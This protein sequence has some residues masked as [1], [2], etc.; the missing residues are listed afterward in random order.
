MEEDADCEI[1]DLKEKYEQRLG[2]ERCAHPARGPR[3]DSSALWGR[4]NLLGI[5]RPS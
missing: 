2:Y 4:R 1:E 5:S 3:G